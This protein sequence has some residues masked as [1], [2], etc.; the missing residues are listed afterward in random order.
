MSTQKPSITFSRRSFMKTSSL[1]GGGI[2]IG[3]NL[4]NACKP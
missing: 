1:A 2:L 3:F 4:F